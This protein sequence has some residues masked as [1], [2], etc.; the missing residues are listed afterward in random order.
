MNMCSNVVTRRYPTFRRVFNEYGVRTCKN[1]RDPNNGLPWKFHVFVSY[2]VYGGGGDFNTIFVKKMLR[3]N[4][5]ESVKIV[6]E[7]R[8]LKIYAFVTGRNP[9]PCYLWHECYHDVVFTLW[10]CF[11]CNVITIPTT[12]W[13]WIV[14][15]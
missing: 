11:M 10:R 4:N 14:S 6:H 8:V 5:S 13:Y 1:T 3:S 9:K 7:A 2:I 15:L 12:W